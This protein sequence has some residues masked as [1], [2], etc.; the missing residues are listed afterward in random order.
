MTR[1]RALTRYP[2]LDPHIAIGLCLG[3]IRR[4]MRAARLD[5]SWHEIGNLAG[6][7]EEVGVALA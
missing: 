4:L 5:R 1:T 3:A 6:D 2:G 7:I